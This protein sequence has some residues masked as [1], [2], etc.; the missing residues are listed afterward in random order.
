LI[1]MGP[2]IPDCHRIRDWSFGGRR[3]PKGTSWI[4]AEDG[5]APYHVLLPE[6]LMEARSNGF[7][8]GRHCR[9]SVLEAPDLDR[10]GPSCILSTTAARPFGPSR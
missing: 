2:P 10:C 5:P 6:G 8:K 7:R 1:V 9:W 4:W 3:R